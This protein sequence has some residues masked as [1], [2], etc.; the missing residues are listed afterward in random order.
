MTKLLS[1]DV[2]RNGYTLKGWL[3][4]GE[5]FDVVPPIRPYF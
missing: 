1:L 4:G 5:S 2:A 3:V